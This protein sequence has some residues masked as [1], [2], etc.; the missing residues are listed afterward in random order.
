MPGACIAWAPARRWPSIGKRYGV[1]ASAIVAANNLKSGE[2]LEG[3]R[4]LI[5]AIVHAAQQKAPARHT[6]TRG[7]SHR[8]SAARRS[9]TTKTASV[10]PAHKTPVTV[11]RAQ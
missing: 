2:A 10:A 7:G 9:Q 4:L 6:A 1:P 5:P 8:A 3:D 11:A